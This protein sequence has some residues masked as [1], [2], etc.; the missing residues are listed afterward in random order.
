MKVIISYEEDKKPL[1][2]LIPTAI[3]IKM[4]PRLCTDKPI[5]RYGINISEKQI[6][7]IERYLREFKKNY[8][9]EWKEQYKGW[10]LVE[11]SSSTGEKV[12]II[13]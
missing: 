3:F 13:L 12:E 4:I 11:I 2:L 6:K 5:K 7:K 1:K 9:K 10:K 8:K